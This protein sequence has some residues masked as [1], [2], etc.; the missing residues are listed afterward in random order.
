MGAA[1]DFLCK[2]AELQDQLRA[3]GDAVDGSVIEET[4]VRLER[5]HYAPMIILPIAKFLRIKKMEL[6]EEIERIIL[7]SDDEVYEL[8]PGDPRGYFDLKVQYIS[9]LVYYYKQLVY[10]RRG[11]PEAWDEVGELYVHD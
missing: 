6:L 3:F 4:A 5:L 9:V 7:L 2:V 8:S 11:D 1:S 10:L